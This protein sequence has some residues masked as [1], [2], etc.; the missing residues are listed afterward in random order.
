MKRGCASSNDTLRSKVMS[1]GVADR[2]LILLGE[3][4]S[5]DDGAVS[6]ERDVSIPLKVP[7]AQLRIFGPGQPFGHHV[8][9]RGR[10][11]GHHRLARRVLD[12]LVRRAEIA[13]APVLLLLGGRVAQLV[14]S[15]TLTDDDIRRERD[16]V[17]ETVES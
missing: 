4:V 12:F 14:H 10:I 7:R 1:R 5:R 2:G 17:E 11:D 16:L 15:R 3:L 6:I 9:P 13:R 8:A